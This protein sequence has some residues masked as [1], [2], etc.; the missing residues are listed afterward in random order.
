MPSNIIRTLR[1]SISVFHGGLILIF[2]T[3]FMGF[4]T[5]MSLGT[6]R[7]IGPMF[8]IVIGLL[9]YSL[10]CLYIENTSHP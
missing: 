8:I 7:I 6:M 10:S 5:A 3:I 1:T 9:F 2:T 4:M